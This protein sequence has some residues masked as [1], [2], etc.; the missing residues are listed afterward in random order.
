MSIQTRSFRGFSYIIPKIVSIFFAICLA[1]LSPG[2]EA[3]DFSSHE[4]RVLE[5]YLAYYGRPADPGG[6]QYWS[7]RLRNEGGNI[8]SIINAFGESLEYQQRFGNLSSTQLVTNLYQQLF[9]RNP[10]SGGLNF[11]VGKLNSGEWNLQRISLAILDGI[12]GSDVTIVNNRLSFSKHFVSESESD[13]LKPISSRQLANLIAGINTAQSSLNRAY[14]DL[15]D[16]FGKATG[17]S[18]NQPNRYDLNGSWS[19]QLVDPYNE[20]TSSYVVTVVDNRITSEVYAGDN[21]GST[22]L[23]SPSSIVP[24]GF[25]VEFS[26]GVLGSFIVDLSGN[27]IS[28]VS[29]NLAFGV[30]QRNRLNRPSFDLFDLAGS[31]R[32]ITIFT[33]G[34]TAVFADSSSADCEADFGEASVDCLAIV[35]GVRGTVRSTFQTQGVWLGRYY[36]DLGYYLNNVYAV[37]SNDSRA[38]SVMYCD[39][40]YSQIYYAGC[41]FTLMSKD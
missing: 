4:E 32:G 14:Q 30:V 25:L 6:L 40:Y 21:T 31:Y 3:R 5:A 28:F 36:D 29:E 27:Y 34:Y 17:G 12:Q 11:Y 10:D 26:N 7:N 13:T 9:G 16:D 1:A 22:G 37:K 38:L 19:G 15:E 23:I 24:S 20:V 39:S 18:G 33:D 35:N 2:V 8:N 41:S